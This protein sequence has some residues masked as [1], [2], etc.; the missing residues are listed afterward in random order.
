MF[1]EA[2]GILKWDWQLHGLIKFDKHV[3]A[4]VINTLY[5]ESISVG[6]RSLTLS[7]VIVLRIKWN[8][9]FT[10]CCNIINGW[11]L[12]IKVLVF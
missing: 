8:S 10:Y 7:D 4:L 9:S 12:H 1:F 5:T 6:K 11:M 3:I 2:N